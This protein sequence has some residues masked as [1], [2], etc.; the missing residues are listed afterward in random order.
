MDKRLEKKLAELPK[1]AIRVTSF[2]AARAHLNTAIELWVSDSDPVSVHTL[3]FAAYEVIHDLNKRAKGSPLLYDLVPEQDKWE[4]LSLL[5][6]AAYFFKHAD[7][8][9]QGKARPFILF[10][11]MH[12]EVF[13]LSALEGMWHFETPFNDIES[14]FRLWQAVHR[15]YFHDAE[16]VR[17]LSKQIPIDA[18][19]GL[20]RYRKKK[21]FNV[22]CQQHRKMIRRGTTL[23]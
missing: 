16:F 10:L 4:N 3:A 7:G 5:K 2:N 12:S 14:A 18:W 9:R 13:M 21:F 17:D 1:G 8:R 11:P 20:K 22:V 15:P 23:D 6:E 19:R